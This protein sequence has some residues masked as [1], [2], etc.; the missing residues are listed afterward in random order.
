MRAGWGRGG[1]VVGGGGEEAC[2]RPQAQ[3]DDAAA[4]R[5]VCFFCGYQCACGQAKTHRSKRKRVSRVRARP[6]GRNSGCGCICC[7]LT[8][9]CTLHGRR[10]S[11]AAPRRQ[12]ARSCARARHASGRAAQQG[13]DT[14]RTAAQQ[15]MREG[16]T[17]ARTHGNNAKRR[18]SRLWLRLSVC[19]WSERRAVRAAHG[20]RQRVS[21]HDRKQEVGAS[22]TEEE[23]SKRAD[24]PTLPRAIS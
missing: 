24:P 4:A 21:R 1:R 14:R 17:H 13:A 7:V 18:R 22:Q 19:L 16:A 5:G 6:R 3:C 10:R 8:S 9:R 11:S 12:R 2:V 20:M 15:H 23:A